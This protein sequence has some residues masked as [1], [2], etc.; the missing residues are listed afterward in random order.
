[1]ISFKTFLI[2]AP[3][4]NEMEI[5]NKLA[6]YLTRVRKLPKAKAYIPISGANNQKVSSTD[7]HDIYRNHDKENKVVNTHFYAVNKKTNKVDMY[8]SGLMQGNRKKKFQVSML[9]ASKKG[10]IR[11]HDFYHHLIHAGH[12]NSLI[13]DDSQSE[14]AQK[15]WKRLSQSPNIKMSAIRNSYSDKHG[16]R[17]IKDRYNKKI[18][19]NYSDNPESHKWRR[20]LVAKADV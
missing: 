4:S 3:H 12:I 18:E 19:R 9:K 6:D 11:A 15:V 13:S 1:M 10:E 20:K 14:G 16:W 7:T 2:E 5:N 8:V 17:Q